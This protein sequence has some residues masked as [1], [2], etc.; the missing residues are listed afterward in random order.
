MDTNFFKST[1]LNN[2]F[3]DVNK[4]VY[5]NTNVN[6]KS[7]NKTYQQFKK[8][9]HIVANKFLKEGITLPELNDKLT[10]NA[11][12]F[13]TNLV[14]QKKLNNHSSSSG[15][16]IIP[17]SN[18][19][20]NPNDYLPPVEN[21]VPT[22]VSVMS[23]N[24]GSPYLN[25]SE[26][27]VDPNLPEVIGN[28]LP[29]FNNIADI[30]TDETINIDDRVNDYLTN[31]N[32][33]MSGVEE[34][35]SQ[36]KMYET[37]I[38]QSVEAYGFNNKQA[39]LVYKETQLR[40]GVSDNQVAQYKEL[41]RKIDEKFSRITE[42]I[43]KALINPTI[44]EK[45][46]KALFRAQNDSQPKY[47]ERSNYIIV[48]SA[49]RDWLN[50]S[51]DNNNRYNF[52]VKFGKH[53]NS[54][55]INNVY[56]NIT[57]IELVNC[58]MPKDN[59]L[60]P[61]DTRPYI[62]ILT[63]PYLVLKIPE[64]TNV[65]RGTNSSTDNAFSV[66]MYDKKHDSQ[67]LSNDLVSG[68]NSIVNSTPTRQFYSEYNKS[69]YKYLPAYFEKK[70]FD[71]QPLASLSHM[72]I[73]IVNPNNENINAMRDVLEINEIAFTA[74]ISGLSSA[75]FEYDLTNSF[76]NDA[77][78]T[79]REYLRIKTNSIFSSKLYR[80]GD[81]IKISG[82]VAAAGATLAEQNLVNY[83][84]RSEGHYILNFD[85]SN[86]AAG[87]NQ[88]FTSNIYISPPGDINTTSDGN[89]TAGTYI[90]SASA[91]T[92]NITIGSSRLINTHL[93]THFLFKI[94]TREGDFQ[95]VHN[96]MNI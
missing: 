48:N 51:L 73:S 52:A 25:N 75:N 46:F 42:R 50:E 4:I 49:D 55:S 30:T 67:V 85:V 68:S 82:L 2:I 43:E 14:N 18:E 22:E 71:N 74:D 16:D 28:E 27:N 20:G 8:M 91:D 32:N 39:E 24:N 78:A 77:S 57:S 92:S 70:V 94:N 80:L 12:S 13:F 21:R 47:M 5:Q 6:I 56:K 11:T 38:D 84:N 72:S 64:L 93:Q 1:N 87:Q 54:A 9:A 60:I 31:R 63:Y 33:I 44:D 79:G 19:T 35:P 86:L 40:D 95:K 23:S 34:P 58:F 3:E 7:H 83:L 15:S 90:D 62:D 26:Y 89:L 29:L 81:N 10:H 96:A 61:F 59:V 17:P 88:G 65:F 41:D 37:P 45:L 66:L 36:R 53:D 76:P 69:Y